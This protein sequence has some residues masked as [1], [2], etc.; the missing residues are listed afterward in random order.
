LTP[1][2]NCCISSKTMPIRTTPLV[3]K[4]IYHIVNRGVN[5]IPIFEDQR[6]YNRFL[7]ISSYYQFVEPPIKYSLFTKLPAYTRETLQKELNQKNHK[8]ISL[9]AF[10]LMPNHFHLLLRQEKNEGISRFLANIQN[11]YTRYYNT[12]HGRIG[13]L[14]Q[15]QFKA[16]RVA[17][18]N[19]LLH[20]SRYIHLNPYSSFVVK[21][22]DQ[23]KEYP[24]SSLSQ[25]IDGAQGLCD[26]RP[27]LSNFSSK[28][29]Y[30]EFVENQKDYQMTLAQI[31]HLLLEK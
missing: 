25:Y 20:T 8:L 9:L 17:S 28:A 6:D 11:S 26:R 3:T 27:V 4:E 10:C 29:K 24:W 2:E 30:L 14:F 1:R 21:S 13:H 15:G 19:Q 16:V 23:L 22:F 7:Q 12:R 18:E 31:K 5:H